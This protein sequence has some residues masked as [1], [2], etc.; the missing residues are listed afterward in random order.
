V[1]PFVV[2][3]AEMSI[4]TL[5]SNRDESLAAAQNEAGAIPKLTTWFSASNG[6]L[7]DLAIFCSARSSWRVAVPCGRSTAA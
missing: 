2:T 6:R 3:S 7:I 4:D 5:E 1:F